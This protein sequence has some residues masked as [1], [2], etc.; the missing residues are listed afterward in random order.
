MEPTTPRRIAVTAL[1]AAF[2][3]ACVWALWPKGPGTATRFHLS[4]HAVMGTQTKL[5]VVLGANE[6]AR[7]RRALSDA[8]GALRD[9]EAKMSSW[10]T[11]SELSRL[12][13]A[14]AGERTPLSPDTLRVLRAARAF[15]EE[16][17]GAF[18]VTC[19]PIIELWKQAGKTGKLPDA[20]A[21]AAAREQSRWEHI[22]LQ[23]DGATKTSATAS[24]DLGG[25][26]KGYGI[27]RAAEALIAAGA[28]GGLL[29]VGGDVRCFGRRDTSGPWQVGIRSPFT[30]EE[31]IFAVLAIGDGAVCTSGN[32]L[33][34]AEIGGKRYS[35]IVD[36][37]TGWPVDAA[38]SVTVVA[39]TAM[40]ADAW[41][42]ALS[43]LGAAGLKLLPAGEGIEA[44]IVE[45]GPDDYRIHYSDGFEKFLSQRPPA[46]K[47][48]D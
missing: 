15:A 6:G 48:G 11:A 40:T 42:T 22:E 33:R 43:V 46:A 9:V 3:A 31:S 45:G 28:A 32:Y 16:T 20:G 39:K 5:T 24:V 44:M 38:P 13:A 14:P 18:D 47:K 36:P 1:A 12:N 37:R 25:I 19:R 34:F 4:L 17:D 30:S 2:V 29:D 27:D 10:L 35:H 7:A 41:A 21:L 26:A 8:E 23:A